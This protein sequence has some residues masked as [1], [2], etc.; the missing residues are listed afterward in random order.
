MKKTKTILMFCLL[1]GATIIM[2]SCK[3]II[4]SV[5]FGFDGVSSKFTIPV[6]NTKGTISLGTVTAK[7]TLDSIK[8]ANGADGLN[9]KSLVVKEAK[10]T[11]TLPTDG[12]FDA[13]DNLHLYIGATG[14]TE[15]KLAYLDSIPKG[16]NTLSMKVS[17]TN[18]QQFFAKDYIT[19]RADGTTNDSIR[20]AMEI[21]VNV[22]YSVT[23]E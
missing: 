21:K 3:K 19:L 20:K 11:I 8:K 2:G 15:E 22:K 6:T 23:T 9:I 10:F 14:L 13:F 7:S 4:P 1:A 5:T 18:I 16:V 12:N 17:S